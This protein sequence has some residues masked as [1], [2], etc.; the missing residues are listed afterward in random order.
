MPTTD[1]API[2]APPGREPS[3]EPHFGDLRKGAYLKRRADYL[4]QIDSGVNLPTC[5]IPDRATG[6][7]PDKH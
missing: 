7:P 4:L 2:P 1:A 3:P 5:E 6:N